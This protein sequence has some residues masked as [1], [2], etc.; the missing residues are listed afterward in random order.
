[1]RAIF[2]LLFLLAGTWLLWQWHAGPRPDPAGAAMRQLRGAYVTPGGNFHVF[3]VTDEGSRVDV[4]TVR[5]W[6]R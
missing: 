4:T 2:T 5:R 1:M 3:V 6:R